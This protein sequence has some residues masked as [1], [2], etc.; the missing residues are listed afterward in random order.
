MPSSIPLGSTRLSN[1]MCLSVGASLFGVRYLLEI[2]M[3]S[4]SQSGS[5]LFSSKYLS[6]SLWMSSRAFFPSS[7]SW[8]PAPSSVTDCLTNL[9]L[10]GVVLGVAPS[11]NIHSVVSFNRLTWVSL[12][13]AGDS[14]RLSRHAI[15]IPAPRQGSRLSW[16][17][18]VS[19]SLAPLSFSQRSGP[20]SRLSHISVSQ[21]RSIAVVVMTF[22]HRC[23]FRKQVGPLVHLV[24]YLI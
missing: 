12:L 21:F 3:V 15:R 19:T 23:R 11:V 7:K 17:L 14:S 1:P 18:R 4:V 2:S 20:S 9:Y 10:A 16:L 6:N 24:R 8:F 22:A 5:R 13:A